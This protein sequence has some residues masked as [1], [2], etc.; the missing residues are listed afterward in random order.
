MCT[1]K[2]LWCKLYVL[3]ITAFKVQNVSNEANVSSEFT[4]LSIVL[5]MLRVW[6]FLVILLV[7]F[8]DIRKKKHE[9]YYIQQC[10]MLC[11][12]YVVASKWLQETKSHYTASELVS[13]KYRAAEQANDQHLALLIKE[14]IWFFT[15]PLFTKSY[16]FSTLFYVLQCVVKQ[17]SG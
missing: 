13:V 5:V 9:F 15:T 6:P 7:A 11:P 8:V 12:Y 3:R 1:Y 16:W 4:W 14:K 2:R 17:F 10:Q